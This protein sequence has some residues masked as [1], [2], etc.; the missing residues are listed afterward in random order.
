MLHQ[1][2]VK[3]SHSPHLSSSSWDISVRTKVLD[4]LSNRPTCVVFPEPVSPT[5]STTLFSLMSWMISTWR[6]CTGREHRKVSS[7]DGLLLRGTLGMPLFNRP[8]ALFLSQPL[9]V[10]RD[11]EYYNTYCTN[12]PVD[13]I[14]FSSWKAE[15][16]LHGMTIKTGL[17]LS[18]CGWE[19]RGGR[20]CNGIYINLLGEFFHLETVKL[21]TEWNRLKL[22]A[23][24][25]NQQIMDLQRYLFISDI[26]WKSYI[27]KCVDG[28]GIE[29][30]IHY[31]PTNPNQMSGEVRAL[32]R[33]KIVAFGQRGDISRVWREMPTTPPKIGGR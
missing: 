6:S 10:G 11:K 16:W 30:T 7:S 33:T 20:A 3:T 12:R 23:D 2:A 24:F 8:L 29:K 15:A 13:W 28:V 17:W 14:L 22:W 9:S 5:T 4:R 21:D 31:S 26:E 25:D 18:I 19:N 27:T 1:S 32:P